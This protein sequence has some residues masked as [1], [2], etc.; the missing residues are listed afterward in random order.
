MAAT[1][2]IKLTVLHTDGEK[3]NITAGPYATDAAALTMVKAKIMQFNYNVANNADN[4][5]ETL[6]QSKGGAYA[7]KDKM[8]DEAHIITVKETDYNL[9]DAE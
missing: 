3:T 8:I 9:N 2:E 6:I 7:V 5:V 4:G 1:S